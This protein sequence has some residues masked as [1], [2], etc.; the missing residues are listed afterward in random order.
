MKDHI[1]TLYAFSVAILS[2]HIIGS[3]LSP[4][5][6]TFRLLAD[7]LNDTAVILDTLSPAFNSLPIPGL[8]VGSL[9]L[10]AVF[11]SLCGISAGGSKA[12]ITMHFDTPLNGK[13]DEGDLNAKDASKETVLALFGMLVSPSLLPTSLTS[14]LS[15]RNVDCPVFDDVVVNILCVVCARWVALDLVER[16]SCLLSCHLYLSTN[17]AV[18]RP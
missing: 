14:Y 6:K 4:E 10:S 5:A 2:A 11:K 7:V 8:R 9:C 3:S 12:A 1:S 16:L 17:K 15:V 18:S 13:G